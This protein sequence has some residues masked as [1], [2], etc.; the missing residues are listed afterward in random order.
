MFW[1]K[2]RLH[3]PRGGV[4]NRLVGLGKGGAEWTVGD[5]GER[6][7][8]VWLFDAVKAGLRY[9]YHFSSFWGLLELETASGGPT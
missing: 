3:E 6:M 7:G 4:G 1:M 8:W 5:L 9:T 2:E